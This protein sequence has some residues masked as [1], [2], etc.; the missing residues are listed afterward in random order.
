MD[1]SDPEYYNS[2]AV[3]RTL[4]HILK[5]AFAQDRSPWENH[6]QFSNYIYKSCL[7]DRPL[8]PKIAPAAPLA[9]PD[10]R[11][12]RSWLGVRVQEVTPEIAESLGLPKAKGALVVSLTPDGAAERAGIKQGDVIETYGARDI[13]KMRDLPLAVAE[14]QVG[15]WANVKLWRNGQ[16]LTLT[17]T[18]ATMPSNPETPAGGT[19][20]APAPAPTPL[21][22]PFKGAV[23]CSIGHADGHI[24]KFWASEKECQD[25]IELAK[26]ESRPPCDPHSNAALNDCT[27]GIPGTTECIARGRGWEMDITHGKCVRVPEFRYKVSLEILREM[28][29]Y[30]NSVRMHLLPHVPCS[31]TMCVSVKI[32]CPPRM[33]TSVR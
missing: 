26:H 15:Q 23:R 4:H 19:P 5:I 20:A 1:A 21:S 2:P 8:E 29:P 18:I 30:R 17:P 3:K 9:V 7:E 11:T 32:G 31:G 12:E 13:L 25:K 10:A 14:T 22:P 6:S 27:T 24:E 33:L 28:M 16:E